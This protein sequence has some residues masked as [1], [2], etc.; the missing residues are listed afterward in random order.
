MDF[1]S[2]I[3]PE[4]LEMIP[5]EQREM[6]KRMG[7]GQPFSDMAQPAGGPASHAAPPGDVQ[8]KDMM[9]AAFAGMAQMGM[10]SNV[11]LSIDGKK[12]KGGSSVSATI[13]GLTEK[14]KSE[15]AAAILVPAGEPHEKHIEKQRPSDTAQQFSQMMPFPGMGAQFGSISNVSFVLP[16]EGGN[17]EIRLFSSGRIDNS[18]LLAAAPFS[19]TAEKEAQVT[20]ALEKEEY[21]PKDRAMAIV[22]N[23]SEKM[24]RNEAFI[25]LYKAGAG[26]EQPIFRKKLEAGESWVPVQLSEDIGLFELRVFRDGTKPDEQTPAAAAKLRV[27]GLTCPSCGLENSVSVKECVK[28]GAALQP[29]KCQACGYTDNKPGSE[30]CDICGARLSA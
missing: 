21:G 19:A 12:H 27:K 16:Y 30:Y 23:I 24:V 13:I 11:S 14:M 4:Q 6:I 5:P 15:G 20:I 8:E 22:N 10:M 3:P 25:G 26:N 29:G 7:Q 1:F 9:A 17:F 18:T 2:M 28:C